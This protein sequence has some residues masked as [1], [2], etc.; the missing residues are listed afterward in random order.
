MSEAGGIVTD[1]RG[2]KL[3]FGLGRTLGANY[4][5]IGAGKEVHASILK[6][7][8]QAQEESTRAKA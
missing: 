5:V 8:Q 3:N 1:S 6:A 7:V 4:G 2:E